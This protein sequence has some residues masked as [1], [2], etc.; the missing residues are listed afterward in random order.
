M[1]VEFEWDERKNVLNLEKHGLRFE[2]AALVFRDPAALTF[3][4]DRF[5]YG[6]ARWATI[7]VVEAVIL[8]VAHS[9]SEDD[10]GEE[11]IRIISARQATPRER[12]FYLSR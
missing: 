10:S 7:G 1:T 5:D 11:I 2:Y 6:E 8:Y 4:D 3:L 12:R 9:T